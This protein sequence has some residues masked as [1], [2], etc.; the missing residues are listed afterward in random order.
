[1]DDEELNLGGRPR[2]GKYKDEKKTKRINAFVAESLYDRF[3][4][5]CETEERYASWTV[6]K[7]LD[8]YLTKK[9]Y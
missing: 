2:L 7:A 1:M 8:E 6:T 9:G 3:I 4:K 5:F